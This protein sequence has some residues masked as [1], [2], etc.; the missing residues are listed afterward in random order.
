MDRATRRL[1]NLKAPKASLD[2]APPIPQT[3]KEGEERYAFVNGKPRLYKKLN[4]SMYY[5]ESQGGQY[6]DASEGV[7]NGDSHDH[8]GGDGGTIAYS[9]LSGKPV[10]TGYALMVSAHT[11][12][13]LDSTTYYHGNLGQ[14][15]DTSP[16]F[17]RV[18]VPRAGTITSAY[19]YWNCAGATSSTEG[20]TVN[21]RLNN[22]T[23]TL[24]QSVGN[25]YAGK[26]FSNTGLS[27]AVIAGDYFEIEIVTPAWSANPRDVR[28]GGTVYI[29]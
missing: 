20:I 29:E 4:G 1:S 10:T 22:T 9:S 12:D 24:V 17:H 13:P 3:M 19:I 18:Y 16:T 15:P 28:I 27:I 25:T 6:A 5:W 14:A 26:V 11:F 2:T 7:T 8:L 21:I 23:S